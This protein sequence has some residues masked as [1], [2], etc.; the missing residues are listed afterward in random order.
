MT[1]LDTRSRSAP[2]A[3]PPA[4]IRR[5]SLVVELVILAIGYLAYEGTRLAVRANHAEAMHNG[6][7]VYHAEERSAFA[8]EEWINHVLNAHA[9]VARISGYYYATLHFTVTIAV[10]VWLYWRHPEHYR[11]LRTTLIGTT[12]I[13]L[14]G[15][16]LFPV[17][18][19]RFTLPNLTDTVAHWRILEVAAPRGGSSVANLDAAMP[20]L[21]VGWAAWCAL[22]VWQVFRRRHPV[23][24]LLA[25]VYPVLTT[26]VVLGTAN[27]Y[28]LDC[29]AGLV[30]LGVGIGL[31]KLTMSRVA[32]V[33]GT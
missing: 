7:R 32:L 9:A 26:I 16:W 2:S 15:Y 10:I 30:A 14:L 6:R 4:A 28:L 29:V 13:A 31:G 20:S 1:A 19:P 17:A 18:P 25:F 33:L 24:A 11:P 21:H 27:H 12:L 5:P 23:L 8:P 3:D 22:V